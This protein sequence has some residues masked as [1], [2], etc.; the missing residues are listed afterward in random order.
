MIKKPNVTL[1]SQ[2]YVP[3]LPVK[4]VRRHLMVP[5][6]SLVRRHMLRRVPRHRLMMHVRVMHHL[7]SETKTKP[8]IATDQ[9]TNSFPLKVPPSRSNRLPLFYVENRLEP[10]PRVQDKSAY[11]SSRY[12]FI[13]ANSKENRFVQHAAMLKMLPTCHFNIA[14]FILK[15]YFAVSFVLVVLRRRR[16]I[17]KIFNNTKMLAG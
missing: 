8:T 2:C 12:Y 6:H 10:E 4:L 1:P 14:Y 16:N 17:G 15:Y 3:V 5:R 9:T 7:L 11:K 13:L